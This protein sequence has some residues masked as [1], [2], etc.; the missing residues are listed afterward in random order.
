VATGCVLST[1]QYASHTRHQGLLDNHIELLGALPQNKHNT[2]HRQTARHNTQATP[3]VLHILHTSVE[4]T[5]AVHNNLG[6][7][8]MLH[9]LHIP[10]K[11]VAQALELYDTYNTAR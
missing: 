11:C 6:F 7:A 9:C 2:S 5:G 4:T 3:A 1:L 8:A 10:W